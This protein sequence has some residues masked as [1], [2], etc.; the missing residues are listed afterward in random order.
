[1][2]LCRAISGAFPMRWW[3]KPRTDSNRRRVSRYENANGA[4]PDRHRSAT[5][6]LEVTC[7]QTDPRRSRGVAS[8]EAPMSPRY[9]RVKFSVNAAFSL[10]WLQVWKQL[11]QI[12][13]HRLSAA[14]IPSFPPTALSCI[15][16]AP[17]MHPS[18]FAQIRDIHLLAAD[19]TPPKL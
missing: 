8:L 17:P 9:F 15:S 2:A 4:V 5:F 1:M 16:R 3:G 12:L 7:S 19:F 11:T 10:R 18:T 13:F 14:E 6:D